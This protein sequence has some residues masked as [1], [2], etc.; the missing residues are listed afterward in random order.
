MSR[1]VPSYIWLPVLLLAAACGGEKASSSPAADAKPK[2][3][4]ITPGSIAD[5]AWNSGAFKGLEQI[6]DSL[7]L[8]VSHV[9]ARTPAEQEDALR[10]YAVQGY[11]L[12]FA[13][14][15]E[16]QRPAERVAKDHPGTIFVVTSGSTPVPGVVPLIF[17]LHDATYLA[18]MVS[19][20][21]TKSGTIAFIG[22]VEIPPVK[23]AYQ[24]WVNGATAVNAK[25]QA[26]S[27]YLNT[28]D[29]AAAG[30]EQAIAF[31]RAGADV[32][33]HNADAAALG[34]FQA[35][36]E[37]KTAL[38][39]GANQDQASLA[40]ANVPGSAVIDLPRAFVLIAHQIIT[41]KQ[42]PTTENVGLKEGVVT[43]V[44]N[45]AFSV[46]AELTARVQAAA[47]S[48][49]AGTLDPLK[50]PVP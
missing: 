28:W 45:P 6:R 46:P 26:R 44:A 20:G 17:R 49:V 24:A 37:S 42:V 10:T 12:V 23:L 29:D 18:G 34:A 36:K 25:V 16:F 22:G 43:Y 50:S 11:R 39:F 14:G 31:L 9:E 21:M 7:G 41:D 8:E 15:F 33:H 1:R 3:A 32:L 2:V 48:I 27:A 5:A 4:L 38:I 19:G 40:P 47:D 30:R 13:H 35:V